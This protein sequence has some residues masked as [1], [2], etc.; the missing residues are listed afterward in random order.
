MK[1]YSFKT[2]LLY[3][4]AIYSYGCA[5]EDQANQPQASFVATNRT[6]IIDEH[7]DPLFFSGINLGNW[8]LWEGYLMMGDYEY[9]THTQFL[10]ELEQAFGSKS[11]ALEFEL[12]WRANYVTEQTIADLKDL[13]FNS[14]RVPFSY[15]LVWQHIATRYAN[16]PQMWGYNIG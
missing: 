6:H 11:Q 7:G 9:R 16:E 1:L 4:F 8:L 10:N 13:G 15:T 2:A 12:Q 3:A 14:V 5:G